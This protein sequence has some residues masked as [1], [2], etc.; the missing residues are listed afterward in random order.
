MIYL[1][2]FRLD[3]EVVKKRGRKGSCHYFIKKPD[4]GEV[5]EFKEEGVFSL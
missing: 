5:F 3:L 2:T 1:P 4:T